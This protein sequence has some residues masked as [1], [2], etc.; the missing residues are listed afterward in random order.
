MSAPQVLLDTDILSLLMRQDPVVAGKAQ[1]YLAEHQR[2]TLSIITRY[3]VLRGLKSK[4]AAKREGAFDQFCAGSE[5][6]PLTE[7]VIVK[8]AEIYANLYKRGELVGDADILIAA[9]ALTNGFGVTTNNERHF[10][11]VTGLYVEN[12]RK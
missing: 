6:L 11:R 1:D 7:N 8:A 4:G 9:T 10:E 2:F 5:V 12:W 3:E